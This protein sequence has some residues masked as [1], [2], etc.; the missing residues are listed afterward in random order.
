[1]TDLDTAPARR[2]VMYTAW[3]SAHVDVARRSAE[4]VKRH[5]PDLATAIWCH[6]DDD[7]S[8]FDLAYTVPEGMKRPKVNLL[9]RTPFDETL[10]LDNDTLV[11]ADLGPMFDLLSK[12]DMAGAQVALW[13]RPRHNRSISLELPETFPEINCGVLLYRRNDKVMDFLDAWAL[14]YAKSGMKIDQPSFRETL[15]RSDLAFHVLPQQYNK[16]IFEASE[17]VWSD[18]P[19]ARILHLELLQPQKNPV[20]RWLSN[21]LR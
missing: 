11:R 17:L 19:K 6:A 3:G 13:H 21:R 14:A 7:A 12:F 5:N 8:G 9:A 1:M 16:R 10:Y 18:Q 15:W 20:L 2:G 4:S